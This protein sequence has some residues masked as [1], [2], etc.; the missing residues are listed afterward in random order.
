MRNTYNW[1]KLKLEY[2]TSPIMEV[3]EFFKSSYSTYSGHTKSKTK[4]WS[5]EKQKLIQS[6]KNNA[7]KELR[8]NLKEIYKPSVEELSQMYKAIF[9][10]FKLKVLNLSQN[11][12]KDEN[13]KIILPKDLNIRELKIIREIVRTEM[14]LPT[15]FSN[16]KIDINF[17]EDKNYEQVIFY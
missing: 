5:L 13:G 14:G 2:F 3:K 10:I 16:S 17:K 9:Y 15:K 6:C 1:D 12:T 8:E 11:I 7:E 4:W